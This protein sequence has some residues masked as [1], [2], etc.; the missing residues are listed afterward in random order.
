M[1]H[2]LCAAHGVRVSEERTAEDADEGKQTS[3]KAAQKERHAN[4]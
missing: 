2:S 4:R 3:K 1:V